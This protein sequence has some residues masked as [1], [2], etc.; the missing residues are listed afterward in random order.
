MSEEVFK[1]LMER[2]DELEREKNQRSSKTPKQGPFDQDSPNDNPDDPFKPSDSRQYPSS[3][4]HPSTIPDEVSV[5]NEQ[6]NPEHEEQEEEEEEKKK[7]IPTFSG[8]IQIP[9]IIYR[10]IV[11]IS[12]S[13]GTALSRT[14]QVE[15]EPTYQN[16]LKHRKQYDE[17]ITKL[18]PTNRLTQIAKFTNHPGVILSGMLYD[19][20]VWEEKE[21]FFSDDD[22]LSD[23]SDMNEE[24]ENEDENENKK[25]EED[26][27]D[28]FI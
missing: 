9:R 11:R 7:T 15:E 22:I 18:L 5:D 25:E 12:G 8:V 10:G 23:E 14:H 6:E 24:N 1:R 27:D 21:V 3:S 26:P 13:I 16:V 4:P 2:A 19:D 17:Q 28:I 20:M